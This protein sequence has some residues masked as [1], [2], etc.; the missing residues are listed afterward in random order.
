MRPSFSVIMPVYNAEKH[1]SRSLKSIFDQTLKDFELLVYDDASTDQSLEIITSFKDDRIRLF[2]GEKN[3]GSLKA[4]NFLLNQA[5]GRYI[6]FQD[7]DDCSHTKRLEKLSTYFQNNPEVH[8]LGSNVLYVDSNWKEIST[9][10]KPEQYGA[11]QEKVKFSIPVIFATSAVKAQVIQK[12]GTFRT[13]FDGLG[14]Y[15][16]DWLYR[17]IEQFPSANLPEPLYQVQLSPNSNSLRIHNSKKLIGDRIVQFLGSQRKENNGKD[18]LS[19][20]PIELLQDFESKELSAYSQDPSLVYYKR[21]EGYMAIEYFHFALKAAFLAFLKAPLKTRNI[22][23]VFFV[24]RK[25]ALN[26][27]SNGR[28]N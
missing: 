6:A 9:S 2:K 16:Y 8:L 21:V 1:L 18:S 15:D 12:V 22:R 17:I 20:L 7:A 4:R 28:S 23:T 24:M 19:G 27:F 11:I 10:K 3:I 25:W 26:H 5:Q 13:Y 14:N